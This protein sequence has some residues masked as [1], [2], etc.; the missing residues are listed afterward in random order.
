MLPRKILL[1]SSNHTGMGHR[2]ICTALLEKLELKDDVEVTVVDGFELSGKVSLGKIYGPITRTAKEFYKIFWD[3]ST[4]TTKLIEEI[5][6]KFLREKF[7]AYLDELRPDC[8]VALHPAFNEPVI[9]IMKDIGLDALHIALVADLVT[10]HPLWA[11]KNSDCV[12]CPTVEAKEAC[13]KMGVRERRI[14]V[15]GFPVR[16]DFCTDIG[17]NDAGRTGFQDNDSSFTC[18]IM[19]GGEGVG[20]L[21]RIATILLENYNCKI[22]IIA[23]RNNALKKTLE[24]KLLPKYPER[25]FVYGLI[26]NVHEVMSGCDIVITR[27]SPNAM[28]EAVMCN[29]PLIINGAL[30]GQEQG[31]PMYAEKY[32]LGLTCRNINGLRKAMDSMLDNGAAKLKEIKQAQRDFRNPLNAQQIVDFITNSD[33]KLRSKRKR[34]IKTRKT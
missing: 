22:K 18:L 12:I 34:I 5:N 8:I 20:N 13:M 17:L 25:V 29:V 19:S 31:N 3:I 4:A 16:S 6:Y 9:R 21:G 24:T 33:W 10:I 15:F 32:G 2:S 23:G 27:G 1:I 7:S 30:P 26:E 28:M 14:K 11:S